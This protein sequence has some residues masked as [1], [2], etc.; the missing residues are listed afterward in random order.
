MAE[1]G[2]YKPGGSLLFKNYSASDGFVSNYTY[3]V[4]NAPGSEDLF[5]ATDGNGVIRYRDEMFETVKELSE[6]KT[7]YAAFAEKGGRLGFLS[8]KNELYLSDKKS[9]Q[10]QN[11]MLRESGKNDFQFAA[12]DYSGDV[13]LGYPDGFMVLESHSNQYRDYGR[14]YLMGKIEPNNNCYSPWGANRMLI[15]TAKGICVYTPIDRKAA[16]QARICLDAVEVEL[17]K[18]DTTLEKRFTYNRN[19]ITFHFSGFWFTEP[20]IIRFRY[21]LTGINKDWVITK[22]RFVNFANL[23]PGKYTF[24]V[25]ATI[26]HN[27]E[28]AESVSYSFEVL[29]PVWSRLWFIALMSFLIISV[30]VFLFR[31]RERQLSREAAMKKQKIEFELQTLKNQINPHFLF[32]SLNTLAGVIEETPKNAIVYVEKLSAFYRNILKY[33]DMEVISLKEEW[34]VLEDYMYI[35]SQRFQD[36]IRVEVKIEKDCWDNYIPAF[37][38]QM[39]IENAVKHNIISKAKPLSITISG[40]HDGVSVSNTLQLKQSVMDSTGIGLKNIDSRFRLLTGSGITIRQTDNQF[41][42]HFKLLEDKP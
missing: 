4:V 35:L 42:V 31:F 14:A 10:M 28:D 37:T 12:F 25:Q 33:R 13:L 24:T 9:S 19:H 22:D 26:H 1:I 21:K 39:L 23:P 40:N 27:F 32:N 16:H 38:L 6:N 41:I 18:I 20:E 15:G 11:I 29:S 34:Q 5:F 30:L 7:F 17:Q 2:E 36:N 8:G 3:Q